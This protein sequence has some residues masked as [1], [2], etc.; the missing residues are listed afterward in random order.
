MRTTA[1]ALIRAIGLS[2]LAVDVGP[3]VEPH[4]E[5]V[6]ALGVFVRRRAGLT[7][8]TSAATAPRAP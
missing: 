2:E 1:I 4:P 5:A 8:P 6:R 7:P 3:S